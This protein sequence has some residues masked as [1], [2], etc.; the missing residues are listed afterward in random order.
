MP[1][2]VGPQ[3]SR[4]SPSGAQWVLCLRHTF[5]TSLGRQSFQKE[6]KLTRHFATST[7]LQTL[8]FCCV[9]VMCS[10]TKP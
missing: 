5:G 4:M 10:K 6:C 9:T 3:P 7:S 2:S 8:V 1:A